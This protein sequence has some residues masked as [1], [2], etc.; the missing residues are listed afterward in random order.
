MLLCNLL[1]K[2][3][4]KG[5]AVLNPRVWSNISRE[6]RFPNYYRLADYKIEIEIELLSDA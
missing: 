2:T 5:T 4:H 1:I 3:M 6:H